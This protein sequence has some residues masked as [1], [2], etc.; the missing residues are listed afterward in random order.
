MANSL[1]QQPLGRWFIPDKKTN[2]EIFWAESLNNIL[3][4]RSLWQI[5]L[6]ACLPARVRSL[7]SLWEDWRKRITRQKSYTYR[8]LLAKNMFLTSQMMT[9][10]W[11][12]N[13]LKILMTSAF[14]R[15]IK[16]FKFLDDI[17]KIFKI[18]LFY[19]FKFSIYFTSCEKVSTL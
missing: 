15:K 6:P 19:I 5:D 9:S 16:L 13:I 4:D 10:Q 3:R 1:F 18:S 17:I 11:I 7:G 8:K 14:L 12:K 2:N